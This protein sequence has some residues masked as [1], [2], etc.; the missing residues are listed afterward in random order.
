ME[1]AEV[2]V[3]PSLTDRL[4]AP[5][6]RLAWIAALVLLLA[7][8][9]WAALTPE[10]LLGKADAVGYAVCHRITVRSFAFP[11]GR[12]L[13]MCARCSGTFIGV[14]VGMLAPG[15][16]FKRGKAALWPPAWMM[17]VLILFS[18]SWALDG[19]NSFTQLL[20]YDI[21]R[22]YTTTNLIRLTT[23]MLHGLTMGSMVIPVVNATLWAD[24]KAERTMDKP[25]HL[26]ALVG[27]GVVLIAMVY[28]ER[29]VFLYPLAVVSAVGAVAVLASVAL[30]MVAAVLRREN[31]ARTLMDALPLILLGL[32][33]SLILI[34]LID[35]GRFLVFGTWEGF[36]IS[37]L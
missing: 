26:A 15:L 13:P 4:F 16:L 20:P 17:I 34:G 32:A 6:N 35:A 5:A 22:P 18:A 27:I 33:G 29:A 9:V 24:V 30:V 28:S 36:D 21:P 10:G 31:Q 11:D 2:T 1:D 3:R 12:Q 14:V 37:G 7:A 23:G 19:T 8:T 25:W